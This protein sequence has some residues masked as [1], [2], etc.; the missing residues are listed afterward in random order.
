MP[1]GDFDG[2]GRADIAVFRP[3]TG[4]WYIS[5]SANDAIRITQWGLSTDRPTPGDFDGDNRSDPA[6]FRPS[7]GVWYIFQ[8][9]DNTFRA[10]QFGLN[11]DTPVP[12]A[13]LP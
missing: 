3:S 10:N 6:V 7:E 4:V 12:S 13:Y 5:Q 1:N 9:W 8:S 2:D 11:G